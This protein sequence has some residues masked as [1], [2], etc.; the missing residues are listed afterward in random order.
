MEK[1][2]L[3]R[4]DLNPIVKTNISNNN[5]DPNPNI[6]EKYYSNISNVNKKINK[7]FSKNDL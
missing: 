4:G 5:I 3:F 6:L 2:K 1:F 7:N